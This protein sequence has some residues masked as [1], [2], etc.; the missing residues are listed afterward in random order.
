MNNWRDYFYHQDLGAA[1]EE[2]LRLPEGPLNEHYSQLLATALANADSGEFK[3]KWNFGRLAP[4][5]GVDD[6]VVVFNG[7]NTRSLPTKFKCTNVV[8]LDYPESDVT[9][10]G[11]VYLCFNVPEVAITPDETSN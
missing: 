8:I 6:G 3:S 9:L 2:L 10:S 4:T 5:C 1:K 11:R 7:K